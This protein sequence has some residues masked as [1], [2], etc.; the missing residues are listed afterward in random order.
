MRVSS[1]VRQ[2]SVT[3]SGK[4]DNK[5]QGWCLASYDDQQTLREMILHNLCPLITLIIASS[6]SFSDAEWF[7]VHKVQYSTVT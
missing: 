4:I 6:H 1:T 3:T 2:K 7:I 5:K